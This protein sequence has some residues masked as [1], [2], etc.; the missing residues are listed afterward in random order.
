MKPASLDGLDP[1]FRRR[2]ELVL[3]ELHAMDYRPIVYETLR[4]MER[5]R[6][7]VDAGV[8]WT[9]D[10]RHLTGHAADIIDGREHPSRAGMV[11]GWGSWEGGT[12]D[13]EANLRA[14]RFFEALG[15]VAQHHG[16]TWG[17]AWQGTRRDT[18]HVELPR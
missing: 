11:N 7:L 1:E 14:A 6:E 8:S 2:L 9:M 3:S 4:T 5:Q 13:A 15:I 18:P 17:G 10:S 12:L 16:L